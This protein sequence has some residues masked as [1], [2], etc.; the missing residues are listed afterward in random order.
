MQVRI[1]SEALDNRHNRWKNKGMTY[2]L[3]NGDNWRVTSETAIDL[4]TE[5]PAATYTVKY[6]D[7]S[8]TFFLTVV[9][10]FTV[11][12]KLYG[13]TQ[14]LADRILATFENRPSG[15]GVMLSGL[16][17]SGKSLTAKVLSVD[18]RKQGIPTIVVNQAWSGEEFNGF[19]QSIEQPAVIIFDEF[20]KVY[21][22][23]SQE[24]MLTLLDGVYPSKKLFVITCND[25]YRI[26]E[27]MKNR[28]G[29]IF[30]RVDFEGL[31]REFIEEYCMDNLL[32]KEHIAAVGH[33][34]AAFS[35]FNFDILQGLVEEMNRYD[36]TPMEAL[37]WLNAKP[38]H[39]GDSKYDLKLFYYGKQVPE[40]VLDDYQ[41]SW[42]GNPLAGDGVSFYIHDFTTAKKRRQRAGTAKVAHPE[43]LADWEKELLGDP[44]DWP[45][46]RI[47]F[48][49]SDLSGMNKSTGVLTFEKDNWEV[50]L[51]KKVNQAFGWSSAMFD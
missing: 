3:H 50:R 42:S 25:K 12:H 44:D 29:R 28:P 21:N 32:N 16:Q 49:P 8:G 7:F 1:L 15:T 43:V 37:K 2:Y 10:N 41:A 40:G 36:E 30:Y 13:D 31:T 9:D 23:E 45:Y 34:S 5:L 33:M 39:S 18:A 35:D 4:R 47:S 27:H 46:R 48:T 17:G 51:T 6:D 19:I 14:K 11:S 24:Q 26:N 38:Q 20:E 22:K